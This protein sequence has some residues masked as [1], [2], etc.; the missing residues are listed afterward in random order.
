M[1]TCFV[2]DKMELKNYHKPGYLAW[3]NSKTHSELLASASLN[4][5]N[6]L[7]SLDI[8]EIDLQERSKKIN[9]V[10]SAYTD[11]PFRCIA[12]DNYG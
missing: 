5:E 8:L 1:S 9:V 3:S 6:G 10:G 7:Y 2:F 12:W 11:M 4:D